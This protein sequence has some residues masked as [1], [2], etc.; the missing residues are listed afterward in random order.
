MAWFSARKVREAVRCYADTIIC[1]YFLGF[2]ALSF[3]AVRHHGCSNFRISI[4]LYF[5]KLWILYNYQ[6]FQ[7]EYYTSFHMA[8]W[9]KSLYQ[10]LSDESRWE[11]WQN[12]ALCDC[13]WVIYRLLFL[14]CQDGKEAL[15]EK[16]AIE[17]GQFIFCVHKK[18]NM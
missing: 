8:F 11:S 15:L 12:C 5:G 6:T 16:A 2:V 10:C 13:Q 18:R 17:N 14:F 9:R 3:L 4:W 1:W 7:R